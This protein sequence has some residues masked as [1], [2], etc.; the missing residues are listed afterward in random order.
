MST[1]Q[2]HTVTRD[3]SLDITFTGRLVGEGEH[4]SGGSSGYA[5]D[6]NR[7]TT[8]RLY[9]TAAGKVVTA[10]HQWSRWQGERDCY[11]AAVHGAAAEALAWLVEDAGGDLGPASKEAWLQAAEAEPDVFTAAVEVE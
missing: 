3:G 9:L 8:V 2:R 7:G 4:G 11:R 1:M 10:V 5:S 6:W